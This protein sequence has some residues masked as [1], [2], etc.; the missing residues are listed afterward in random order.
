MRMCLLHTV[1]PNHGATDLPGVHNLY[2]HLIIKMELRVASTAI[3]IY[4]YTD[5][6]FL[7]ACTYNYTLVLLAAFYLI[8]VGLHFSGK[9][10][11]G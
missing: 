8:C 5:L 4:I 2:T 10:Y 9:L 11:S 7:L 6:Y 3:I 1:T